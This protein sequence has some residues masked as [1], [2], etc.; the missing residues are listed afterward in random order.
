[1]LEDL[2]LASMF[3]QMIS[4]K[5]QLDEWGKTISAINGLINQ[6]MGTA[7]AGISAISAASNIPSGLKTNPLNISQT[8]GEIARLFM[9]PSDTIAGAQDDARRRGAMI[10]HGF[11]D[12][13]A[14]AIE[15]RGKLDNSAEEIKKIAQV[16]EKGKSSGLT[17]GN[18]A[19]NVRSDFA[20]MNQA[21]LGM[22]Q[23]LQNTTN[24]GITLNTTEAYEAI[25][26]LG[27]DTTTAKS[28]WGTASAPASPYGSAEQGLQKTQSS[29][30]GQK[31]AAH[32]LRASSSQAFQ[33]YDNL[34][35]RANQIHNAAV[36]YV[37]MMK[38]VALNQETIAHYELSRNMASQ[39][40]AIVSSGLW[41]FYA[42]PSEAFNRMAVQAVGADGM[43]G[44]NPYQWADSFAQ[45]QAAQMGQDAIVATALLNP[46]AYG[47]TIC[48]DVTDS[49]TGNPIAKFKKAP[50]ANAPAK[51]VTLHTNPEKLACGALL[52]K[53]LS[54]PQ[55]PVFDV[56]NDQAKA[57]AYGPD[58]NRTTTTDE[59]A[60]KAAKED[61]LRD[62]PNAG[63]E[64][65]M[66][67]WV[68]LQKRSLWYY[69]SAC[70]TTLAADPADQGQCEVYDGKSNPNARAGGAQGVINNLYRAIDTMIATIN[71]PEVTLVLQTPELQGRPPVDVTRYD[72]VRGEIDE[73]TALAGQQR[74]KVDPAIMAEPMY[75][76]RDASLRNVAIAMRED[77]GFQSWTNT[78][79]QGATPNTS[80]CGAGPC[81]GLADA[82]WNRPVMV[83]GMIAP[84]PQPSP[85]LPV[86][87]RD[88]DCSAP[89]D[90][91]LCQPVQ[92]PGAPYPVR[93]QTAFRPTVMI[94]PPYIGQ[95]R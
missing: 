44:M 41:L 6:V 15:A 8:A 18:D 83:S 32:A 62:N 25:G 50:L 60:T 89:S 93:P 40:R 45:Q 56:Y 65:A 52:A 85:A 43:S 3:Q 58:V 82:D 77:P 22:L 36:S 69:D 73:L 81:W 37:G 12:A 38:T 59:A 21:R 7:K 42:D 67:Y 4:W 28:S 39:Q 29:G 71:D 33:A 13:L 91:V 79:T 87:N 14:T 5:E 95:A 80:D 61:L 1:M 19:E 68:N 74:A 46:S 78:A 27:P 47:E 10:S 51:V 16:I 23:A 92:N 66:R 11:V 20:S 31:D 35:E 53:W 90:A 72:S 94:A 54:L 48:E 76:E 9:Q 34:I 57:E 55:E 2:K 49:E 17:S 75:A 86:A 70:G 63:M 64:Q 30:I 88:I 24:L 26:T 84:M